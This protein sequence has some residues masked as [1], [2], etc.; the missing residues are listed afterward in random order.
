MFCIKSSPQDY[1]SIGVLRE[2]GDFSRE[3]KLGAEGG[4][5]RSRAVTSPTGH[6]QAAER[7]HR[8][9]LSTVLQPAGEVTSQVHCPLRKPEQQ[10]R[11]RAGTGTPTTFLRPQP[12]AW[13]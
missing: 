12:K 2:L 3:G 1:F 7:R 10:S 13:A 4:P 11:N 5:N 6:G 8:Q 9:L